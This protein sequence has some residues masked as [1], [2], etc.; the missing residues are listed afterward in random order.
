MNKLL[1]PVL[2]LLPLGC[3][4]DPAA[5]AARRDKDQA[6]VQSLLAAMNPPSPGR[7]TLQ[8]FGDSLFLFDTATAATWRLG[9]NETWIPFANPAEKAHRKY[10]PKTRRIE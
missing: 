9:T 6:E 5:D 10:N 4:R 1:L 7:Y 3:R 8:N 2:L